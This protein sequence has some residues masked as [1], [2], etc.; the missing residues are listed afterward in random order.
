MAEADE[1]RDAVGVQGQGQ[2][3]KSSVFGT[4][5]KLAAIACF[6]ACGLWGRRWL[7]NIETEQAR[8]L[9]DEAMAAFSCFLGGVGFALLGVFDRRA[10]RKHTRLFFAGLTLVAAMLAG[11]GLTLWIIRSQQ[12][13]NPYP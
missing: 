6:V 11:F 7:F 4:V 1:T 10:G 12:M 8:L 9:R 5:M 2:E 13:Y 3:K